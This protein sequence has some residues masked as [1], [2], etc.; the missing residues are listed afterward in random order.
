MH[1]DRRRFHGADGVGYGNRCVGVGAGIEYDSVAV[2]PC[3]M[4]FVDDCAF[5]VALEI[6]KNNVRIRRF[7]A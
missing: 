1:F 4:D 5:V 3:A 2:E 7:Q 6:F